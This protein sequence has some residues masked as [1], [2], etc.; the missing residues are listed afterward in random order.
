MKEGLKVFKVS[1]GFRY[2]GRV[3]PA[4]APDER[5]EDDSNRMELEGQGQ[6]LNSQHRGGY[7]FT[8]FPFF[9]NNP[10]GYFSWLCTL[11]HVQYATKLS[12]F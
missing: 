7:Y 8:C 9:V 1:C 11:H 2:H 10:C 5:P 12:T 4:P 3:L 6:I